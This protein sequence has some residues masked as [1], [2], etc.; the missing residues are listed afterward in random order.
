M[1][2]VRQRLNFLSAACVELGF[3]LPPSTCRV[4][5]EREDQGAAS[6]LEAVLVAEGMEAVHLQSHPHFN[7][8]IRLYEAYVTAEGRP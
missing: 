2:L 5:S 6:F 8:L 3:C 7:A 4:L 1:T